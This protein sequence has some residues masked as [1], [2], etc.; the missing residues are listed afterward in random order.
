[1]DQVQSLELQI[2]SVR[3]I[4]IFLLNTFLKLEF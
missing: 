2:S 1:M 4:K 3:I